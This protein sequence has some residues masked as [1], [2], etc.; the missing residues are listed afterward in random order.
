MKTN[1]FSDLEKKLK[2]MPKPPLHNKKKDQ[3]QQSLKDLY[4]NSKFEEKKERHSL[5]KPLLS[6]AGAFAIIASLIAFVFV[7]TTIFNNPMHG[8][9][10]PPDGMIFIENDEKTIKT[11]LPKEWDYIDLNDNLIIYPLNKLTDGY[12]AEGEDISL[13]F[14][15]GIV[16]TDSINTSYITSILY[17]ESESYDEFIDR[18]IEK[19]YGGG[20]DG[21][22]ELEIVDEVDDM[23]VMVTTTITNPNN[24]VV[25]EGAVYKESNGELI[26]M[27]F[28]GRNDYS[29][30]D[31]LT[32]EGLYDLFK[33]IIRYT[34]AQ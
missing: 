29:D 8:T 28:Q 31:K 13:T 22:V 1:R 12:P 25:I 3:I 32:N 9:I 4:V 5:M 30:F 18:L 14:N 21:R 20:N 7:A 10:S 2:S 23:P 16:P 17:Q 11:V 34:E 24:E 26:A 27:G 19:Y 15:M 6:G 33:K